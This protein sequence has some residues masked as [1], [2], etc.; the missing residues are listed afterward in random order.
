M[1][2]ETDID[3]QVLIA[4]IGVGVVLYIIIGIKLF[5]RYNILNKNRIKMIF[6]IYTANINR[7]K[8]MLK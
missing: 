5:Y 7:R 1:F 6:S 2:F 3:L 8:A 4:K